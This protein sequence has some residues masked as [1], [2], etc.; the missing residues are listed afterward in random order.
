VS[1]QPDFA[2]ARIELARAQFE[3]GELALSR[4]QFEYLLTQF[5]PAPTRAVIEKYLGAI[6]NRSRLAGSRWSALAQ[7]GA[8]YD[9]NAN[10]S[11]SE[12][13]F[14]GFTLTP[15]N[16]ETESSFGELTLGVGNTVALGEQSGLV[17]NLEV[18]HRANPD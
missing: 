9:S 18:T 4:A 5:P 7:F 17:S 1:I 13:S 12:E 14:L 10:G 8:G 16:V 6:G 2:G 3:R 11:T 15:H